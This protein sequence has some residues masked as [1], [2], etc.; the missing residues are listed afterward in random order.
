M[1]LIIGLEERLIDFHEKIKAR[2]S[3]DIKIIQY[4]GKNMC[5][6]YIKPF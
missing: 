6:F 5:I 1:V 4:A 2:I 3:I